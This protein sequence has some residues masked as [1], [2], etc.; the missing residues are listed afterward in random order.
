[1][2]L[3]SASILFVALTVLTLFA[4]QIIGATVDYVS[5]PCFGLCLFAL[6]GSLLFH[7]RRNDF[8]AG[9]GNGNQWTL[10]PVVSLLPRS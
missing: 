5:V 10:K 9:S 7:P 1:M 2:M 4:G 3:S 8:L 6:L